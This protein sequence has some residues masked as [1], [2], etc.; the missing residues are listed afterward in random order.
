MKSNLAEVGRMTRPI[1]IRPRYITVGCERWRTGRSTID[2]SYTAV[3]W[4]V[5]PI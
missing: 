4:A 1:L 3:P 5:Y 2:P